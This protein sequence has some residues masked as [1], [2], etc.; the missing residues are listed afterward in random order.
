MFRA[1]IEA[2]VTKCDEIAAEMKLPKYTVSRL[3]KKAVDAGWLKKARGEYV[4]VE[5]KN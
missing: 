1:V 4:L 5:A 2:G 3:A